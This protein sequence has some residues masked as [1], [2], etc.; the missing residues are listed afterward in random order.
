MFVD[1]TALGADSGEKLQSLVTELGRVCNRRQQKA[2]VAKNK[3]MKC[4]RDEGT[5]GVGVV[6]NCERLQQIP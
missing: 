2:N 6:L 3:V 5:G 4:C 1:D